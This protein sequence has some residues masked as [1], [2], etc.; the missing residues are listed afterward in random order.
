VGAMVGLILRFPKMVVMHNPRLTMTYWVLQSVSLI[1]IIMW[2]SAVQPW[3]ESGSMERY[4]G[5]SMRVLP[6]P[7]DSNFG[8]QDQP[9]KLCTNDSSNSSAG[10]PT[11]AHPCLPGLYHSGCLPP[12]EAY[13]NEETQTFLVTHVQETTTISD[14]ELLERDYFVPFTDHFVVGLNYFYE[15]PVGD[16]MGRLPEIESLANKVRAS[17]LQNI[18]TVLWGSDGQQ[19]RTVEAGVEIQISVKELLDMAGQ[20]GQLDMPNPLARQPDGH[21]PMSRRSGMELALHID[22]FPS[23]GLWGG[24]SDGKDTTCSVTA[25]RTQNGW[26]GRQQRDVGL[27]GQRRLRELHGIRVKCLAGGISLRFSVTALVNTLTSILVLLGLPQQLTMVICTFLLGHLS[28]VYRQ[29]LYQ[30][31]HLRTFVGGIAL[32]LLVANTA[33]VTLMDQKLPGGSGGSSAISRNRF[34]ERLQAVLSQRC[35][36]LDSSEIDAITDF[37]LMAI[38]NDKIG[39][40]VQAVFNELMQVVVD[41]RRSLVKCGHIDSDSF[42]SVCSSNEDVDFNTVITLLD[43]DRSRRFLERLFTPYSFRMNKLQKPPDGCVDEGAHSSKLRRSPSLEE[44]WENRQSTQHSIQ[45]LQDELDGLDLRSSLNSLECLQDKVAALE[46]SQQHYASVHELQALEREETV[47]RLQ[48]KIADMEVSQQSRAAV[49]EV[50]ALREATIEN[51]QEKV[52]A[53]EAAQQSGLAAIERLQT[54]HK[55]T[56]E[57]QQGVNGIAE[58]FLSLNANYKDL[59]KCHESIMEQFQQQLQ[60]VGERVQQIEQALPSSEERRGT[61]VTLQRA[62]FDTS[63][64]STSSVWPNSVA[65]ERQ[66]M[67]IPTRG[68][69]E[70]LP[71]QSRETSRDN[72]MTAGST[73][74]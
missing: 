72:T 38:H 60:K 26:T 30:T 71:G 17:S 18:K 43:Q 56:L 1:F 28:N 12:D 57:K 9:T 68:I 15:L 59:Q 45:T 23:L 62:P 35:G 37:C 14:G 64:L 40:P 13:Y 2:L 50:E 48:K 54:L 4:I 69:F 41:R 67:P 36:D 22:C 34:H 51:L 33:F 49:H 55:A 24:P 39:G 7:A 21:V 5:S 63:T 65:S 10:N 11:C 8:I 73:S 20:T 46:A 66:R 74:C 27:N 58:K 61:H 47:E 52:D 42:S 25:R 6:L 44:E 70:R 32:R 53:F 19:L 29:V 16:R 31:F 3:T